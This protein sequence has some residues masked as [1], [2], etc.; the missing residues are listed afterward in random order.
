[1][2]VNDSIGQEVTRLNQ[3]NMVIPELKQTVSELQRHK[4]E[5]E[6]QLEEQTRG[7]T[8]KIEEISKKLQMNVEEEASQRRLLEQHEQVEREKEE[9]ER[10]VEELEEVLRRQKNTETEA[11]TRFTQEASRL[12][13]ENMD[14]EEQL[15]MKD[16]LIRKLQ[17]KIKSLQTSEKANQTPAPTIPKEYLGMLE[18]KREDEPKLIQ[19]IILDLKPRG[20]VVNMIPNMAAQLLF[21]CVR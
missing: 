18:Y 1:M 6:E 4:Q 20:V 15:D 11:K 13:A 2:S 8:E 9:V 14:F 3:E 5:L 16:R 10:R 17:N 19:Y 7:M 21:M 12:T